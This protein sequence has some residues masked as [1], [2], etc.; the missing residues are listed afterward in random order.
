MKQEIHTQTFLR[1]RKMLLLFPLLIIPFLTLGFWALGGGKTYQP[2]DNENS[3]GLNLHLPDARFKEKESAD[4]F[5]IYEQAQRDSLQ[6]MQ[7]LQNDPYHREDNFSKVYSEGQEHQHQFTIGKMPYQQDQ[8]E[9]NFLLQQKS[10]GSAEEQVLQKLSQL[11]QALNEPAQRNAKEQLPTYHNSSQ[12]VRFEQEMDRLD[13]MMQQMQERSGPDP[14]MQQ[15][16]GLMDKILDIQHPER[17]KGKPPIQE[18]QASV[19][20]LQA[21][22]PVPQISL[23]AHTDTGRNPVETFPATSGFYGVR[24][25]MEA[26]ARQPVVEAVVPQSQTISSGAYVRLRLLQNSSMAGVLVPSGHFVWGVASLKAERLQIEIN[27]IRYGN[28]LIPVQLQVCDLDGQPGLPL[29]GS[30]AQEAA[31]ES[32]TNMLG[33]MGLNSLEP[34][35]KM[36]ATQVGLGA[37]KNLLS[38]KVKQQQVTLKA[39]YRVLLV[40]RYPNE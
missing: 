14:D 24:N 23:L 30:L 37:V 26:A 40:N 4:K 19:F 34:S 22:G 38:R 31:K 6:L 2:L 35:L 32:T 7:W 29:P 3:K 8:K 5:S 13:H 28:T 21:V 9:V 36:Q 27:S 17:L 10:P 1:R 15:L 33:S 11:N 25:D 18:Q 20:S 12:S 39:G 16:S